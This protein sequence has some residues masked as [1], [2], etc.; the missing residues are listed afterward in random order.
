MK[1]A[2]PQFEVPPHNLQWVTLPGEVATF[3][4]FSSWF[5]KAADELP[6]Y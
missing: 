4:G 5:I 2:W 6:I 1:C 3:K